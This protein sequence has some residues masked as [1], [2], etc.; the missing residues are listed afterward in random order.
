[1]V[2]QEVQ[3]QNCKKIQEKGFEIG[4]LLLQNNEDEAIKLLKELNDNS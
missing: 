3:Y 1:M 2:D 4:S